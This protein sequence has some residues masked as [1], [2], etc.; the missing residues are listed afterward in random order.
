MNNSTINKMHTRRYTSCFILFTLI[1]ILTVIPISK[2]SAEDT[3]KPNESETEEIEITTIDG[4]DCVE[5]EVIVKYK[6]SQSA[7]T[8]QSTIEGLR[9]E[10]E[11]TN[12]S[13]GL[14][15]L[16]VPEG[17]TTENFMKSL[18][19]QSNIQYVQPNYIYRLNRT[20][21]DP[22]AQLPEPEQW[23]LNTI[24]AFEAWDT[25]MGN[26]EVKVAVLDTG[27]DDN[28]P[29][30]IGRIL[31]QEDVVEND[32]KA[33]DD[34]GHGTH[35]AGIIA[36]SADNGEGVAGIAPGIQLIAV[37][38]FGWYT[39]EEDGQYHN[40]FIA[41]TSEVIEGITYA[42]NNG[43]N[44]INMSLGGYGND[45]ALKTAVDNAVNAG[46][47]CVAAAGNDGYD[48]FYEEY[49][50]EYTGEYG[51]SSKHYPS[52]YDSCISVIWTNED[53]VRNVNSNYGPSK[54]ISAPGN[55]IL[56]TYTENQYAYMSGTSMASPIISGVAALILSVNPSLTVDQVKNILYSTSADLGT[57]GRDEEFGYGRV[58]AEAAV[59]AAGTYIPV[60][61]VLLD[62][63][64]VSMF[65]GDTEVLTAMVSPSEA[66][67]KSVM[68]TTSNEKVAIVN[69]GVV[70]AIAGGSATITATTVDGRFIDSCQANVIQRV[71]GVSLDMGSM[72]IEYGQTGVLAA[73]VIPESAANKNVTW[74]SDNDDIA[75]VI[76]GIVSAGGI[77]QTIITVTTEDGEF[78]DTCTVTVEPPMIKSSVYSILRSEGFIKGVPINT[79]AAQLKANLDNNPDQINVITREI[80]E[81]Y[82]GD[83][84]ATGM[85]VKLMLDEQV[86]DELE[87]V[88]AGDCNGD[89]KISITDYT[90]VRL[91]I[92]DLKSLESA[93]KEAADINGDGEISISDYTLIRLDILNLKPIH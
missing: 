5:G 77:G 16:K 74:T 69:N 43:A 34:D 17:Q 37:D 45:P 90:L 2:V 10:A 70:T 39:V 48:D 91:D 51:I 31:M 92:L 44:V 54:D 81:E 87:V 88:V 93:D 28:H 30:L 19:S 89:G 47:V 79:S 9:S 3:V 83:M 80:M 20:V 63:D 15:V 12:L 53:D 57:A 8:M 24:N 7:V 40:E 13:D 73:T 21:N 55:R 4:R 14:N 72:T 6:N 66:Q 62:K 25:T 60:A 67:C 61:G 41:Y 46:V 26:S 22:G 49:Y 84:V 86:E 18:E 78:T 52:D 29:D 58:D 64:T 82:T 68:W 35:V 42:V 65:D 75:T 27:I 71:H 56:S 36:A 38:V 33:D 23:H 11:V 50:D 1:I 32:G 59:L 76:D 85:M